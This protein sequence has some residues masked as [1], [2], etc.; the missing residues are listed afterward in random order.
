MTKIRVQYTQRLIFLQLFIFVGYVR[1]A[2]V[3]QSQQV[4]NKTVSIVVSH[5]SHGLVIIKY[6]K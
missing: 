2:K 3:Y 6:S 4:Q 1:V 5:L